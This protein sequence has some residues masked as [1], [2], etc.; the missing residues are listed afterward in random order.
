MQSFSCQTCRAVHSLSVYVRALAVQGVE[1]MCRECGAIHRLREGNVR[2]VRAGRVG[3][4]TVSMDTPYTPGTIRQLSMWH[5]A[6][7]LPPSEGVYTCKFE[8][9]PVRQF[10]AFWSGS[11]WFVKG[12]SIRLDVQ[13]MTAW[14]AFVRM[15]NE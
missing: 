9:P 15:G 1:H 7:T 11:E 3:R 2:L 5:A 8:G 14:R 10:D 4:P 12:T 6:S 13:T